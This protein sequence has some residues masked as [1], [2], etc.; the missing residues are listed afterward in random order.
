MSC[1]ESS[2]D[3]ATYREIEDRCKVLM[4]KKKESDMQVKEENNLKS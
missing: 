2:E 1:G 3:E 4:E